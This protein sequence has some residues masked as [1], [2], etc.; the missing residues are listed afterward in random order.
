MTNYPS[1][2]DKPLVDFMPKPFP[3]VGNGKQLRSGRITWPYA[4]S[5]RVRAWADSTLNHDTIN[6]T[7]ASRASGAD[8]L[9]RHSSDPSPKPGQAR[10]GIL[11]SGRHESSC[12]YPH[13]TGI[14]G[15]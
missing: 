6:K 8:I 5:Y 9:P 4:R 12:W 7:V 2:F 1:G 11:W 15:P 3:Q 10:P 13:E 14:T